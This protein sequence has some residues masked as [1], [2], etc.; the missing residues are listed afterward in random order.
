MTLSPEQLLLIADM[1]ADRTGARVIDYP[2]LCA[3]AAA[4]GGRLHGVPVHRDLRSAC[5]STRRTIL[6]LSPLD[7][8]NEL[9]ARLVVGVL[10]QLNV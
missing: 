5:T 7:R 9:F 10:V 3:C 4:A 1:V 2:A 6:A 8:D